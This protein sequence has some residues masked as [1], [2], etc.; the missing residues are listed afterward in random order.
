MRA[1]LV[2]ILLTSNTAHACINIEGVTIDGEY[3][4]V[5]GESHVDML[6]ARMNEQPSS[7]LARLEGRAQPDRYGLGVRMVERPGAGE[8]DA[9]RDI[10]T[11]NYN[12]AI[13]KLLAIEH[14]NPD[15][16]NTAANLGTAYELAGDNQSAL[17]WIAEGIKRNENS[18]YG[19]EWL[20]KKILEA[21]IA[22]E[23][24]PN[25]LKSNPI[26]PF[27]ESPTP[28][29]QF[30]FNYDGRALSRDELLNALHYQLGERMLF[31]KPKDPVVADLLYSF[32][33][34]EANTRV[35]EPA[36]E[37][38]KL[39]KVYGYHDGGDIDAKIAKYQQVIDTTFK[40]T[41]GDIIGALVAILFW[42]GALATL[43]SVLY[44][45]YRTFQKRRAQLGE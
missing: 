28:V 26:L 45:M 21:K 24:D 30:T 29:P 40:F 19:T 42:S 33:I 2:L 43:Y 22:M 11:G 12:S 37:L 44:M 36:V 23:R 7:N 16:Y 34:L 18:H 13:E 9:V 38:L 4:M 6:R 31:V 20:H 15:D 32:A 35:L 5:P 25:Y 27:T 1:L 3:R 14:A 8:I 10:L 17:H 39:S 41:W